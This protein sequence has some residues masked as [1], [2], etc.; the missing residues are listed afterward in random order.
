MRPFEEIV[1][2]VNQF[3]DVR[4]L[5]SE[6]VY[7]KYQ[8]TAWRFFDPRLLEVLIALRK[9][10]LCVPLVCNNWRSG[11]NL[12]QRGLRENT[13]EM[14]SKKTK[15]G[16]MYISAHT[17]GKAVDLSS[18]KMDADKMRQLIIAN[19]DKLPYPIRMED[20]KSA[21]TW[22]HIDVACNPVALKNNKGKVQI[23]SD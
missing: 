13:C 5:V 7:K 3:F 8:S 12:Q 19:A 23:F 16:A 17:L 9:S 14:V 18:S 15:A 2:D 1:E 4:E 20:G 11:G 21:P 6:A 22:L 10:I